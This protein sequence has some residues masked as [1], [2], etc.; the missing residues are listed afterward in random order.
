MIGS[1][2]EALFGSAMSS[3][4]VLEIF[5]CFAECLEIFL[6]L[7]K[8]LLKFVDLIV[9]LLKLGRMLFSSLLFL[10]CKRWEFVRIRKWFG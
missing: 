5:F 1:A 6:H 4:E 7:S 2:L 10:S 9:L 8:R 3:L